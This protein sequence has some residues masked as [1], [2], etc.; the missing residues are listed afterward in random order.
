M[1]G[2]AGLFLS[3][4]PCLSLSF[5]GNPDRV[6]PGVYLPLQQFSLF[7]TLDT[8]CAMETNL[9]YNKQ[10]CQGVAVLPVRFLS[11]LFI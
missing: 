6:N 4:S 10:Y 5:S 3:F 2:E 8:I 11:L 1:V 9:N 7:H